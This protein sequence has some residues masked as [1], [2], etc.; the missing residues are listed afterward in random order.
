MTTTLEEFFK[1]RGEI[2]TADVRSEGEFQS[3]HVPGSISI[4]VLN[5]Q[6]RKAVGTDYKRKGKETAI[7]TGHALVAP[8]LHEM[9]EQAKSVAH[10][11]ELLVYCWR[12][13][14]RSEKFCDFATNAGI[15]TRRLQGGYKTYRQFALQTFSKPYRLMVVGG[16]TGSGKTEIL[17]QLKAHGE[18]VIDL[19]FLAN[20]KGSAFGGLMRGK[21]PTTEQFQ[22][23]LFEALMK[24]DIDRRLWIEDESMSIGRVFIPEGFW[25]QKAAAPVMQVEM[26][27][28]ERIERLVNEYSPA[29]RNEFLQSMEKITE[30][31]GG[32]NFNAAKEL[33]LKGDWHG[34]IEI[35]LY[36][37]DKTYLYSL[38]KKKSQI[39]GTVE[40]ASNQ[41]NQPSV[42]ERMIEMAQ[43]FQQR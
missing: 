29:D 11:N 9:M 37:Y 22:N 20:H 12:G 10:A 6:E 4:P 40:W 17:E 43:S 14:L 3:G 8:R 41:S 34:T 26:N 7:E 25:Q 23:N 2:P 33:L 15:K 16:K 1:L 24:I 21:Q 5:D 18:Q 35:L 39:I 36:Y 32:Q 30:R 42:A 27:T 28:T 19:E 31:L 13:G 38:G